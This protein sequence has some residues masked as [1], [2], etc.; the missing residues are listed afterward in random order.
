MKERF[1][2][3]VNYDES[4]AALG[5]FLR[6]KNGAYYFNHNGGNEGFTCASYGSLDKGYGV[7]VM[8]NSNN[9][10]LMLEICNSVARIY[11]WDRFFVP[12]FK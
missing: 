3:V 6:Y 2:P 5:V 1:T 4:K 8:T 12:Q 11:N 7:V 10:E 9:Q